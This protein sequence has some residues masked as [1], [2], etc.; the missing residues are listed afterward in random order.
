MLGELQVEAASI[1]YLGRLEGFQR[2][3]WQTTRVDESEE[4]GI[5]L[6]AGGME[7]AR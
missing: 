5:V 2:F 4:T 1:F 6:V 7:G 3:E